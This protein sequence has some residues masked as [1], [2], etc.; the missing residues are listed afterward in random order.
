MIS[1]YCLVCFYIFALFSALCTFI[2]VLSA[3]F[4]ISYRFEHIIYNLV[5]ISPHKYV[6]SVRNIQYVTFYSLKSFILCAYFL[7]RIHKCAS[8]SLTSLWTQFS[9][10]Y[11]MRTIFTVP[12]WFLTTVHHLVRIFSAYHF[13]RKINQCAML[14]R[15]SE[16]WSLLPLLSS[17]TLKQSRES[18]KLNFRFY[19]KLAERKSKTYQRGQGGSSTPFPLD[20]IGFGFQLNLPF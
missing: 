3:H 11:F 18:H 17:T 6:S 1:A 5:R 4:Y 19:A 13:L 2:C 7:V 14:R 8:Y 20:T 16:T 12:F 10:H 15:L 9:V